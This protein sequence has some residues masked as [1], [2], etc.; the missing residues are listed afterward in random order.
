M[1]NNP[2]VRTEGETATVF[3]GDYLNKLSGEKIE[4]E[5]KQKLEAGARTLVLNFAETEIVNS[6][7]VSILLGVIDAAREKSARV[8]FSDVN[9]DT[10]ELFE[11]LG[12][13]NHVT[14]N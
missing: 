6:I 5:C 2:T 9:D 11:M 3:A 14:V 10:I 1:E 8:V 13:T 4:R 7:G 12:L